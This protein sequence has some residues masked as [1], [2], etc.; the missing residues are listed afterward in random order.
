M[1]SLNIMII[2]K[3]KLNKDLVR[4]FQYLFFCFIFSST[5][6]FG[7]EIKFNGLNRL[8]VND[9]QTI[10]SIPL[11][12]PFDKLSINKL[13]KELYMSDFIYD[14]K[15]NEFSDFFEI[16][17]TES[18]LVKNIYFNGNIQI[19]DN[20]LLS[21]IS[22]KIDDFLKLDNVNQD[23]KNIKN[24]Y[25]SLGYTNLS[26]KVNIE[27]FSG[28]N[29]NL[30]FSI[31]ENDPFKISSI[32]FFGNS[33]FSNRYLRGRIQTKPIKSFNIFSS[34]SNFN[35]SNIDYDLYLIE[36]LYQD[37]GYYDVKVSYQLKKFF[38]KY[39]LDFYINEGRRYKINKFLINSDID[40][41]NIIKK[42][43][44]I[45]TNLEKKI[46]DNFFY[47]TENVD[48][49]LNQLNDTLL[50]NNY[51]DIIFEDEISIDRELKNISLNITTKIN[52][53]IFIKKILINGNNITKDK[54]I[55]SRLNFEPGDTIY[56]ITALEKNENYLKDEAF[57]LDSS[58]KLSEI[59]NNSADIVVD[60]VENEKSGNLFIAGGYDADTGAGLSLG[61]SDNN[62]L[63]TGNKI[64]TNLSL[65]Q[66][67]IFFDIG[68]VQKSIK[69]PN[70]VTRYSIFNK[71][72]DYTSAYGFKNEEV[73]LS[74]GFDTKLNNN[75][76]N[77]I[78]IK[79]SATENSSPKNNAQ[80]ITD[81]IGNSSE[82][83]I[84]YKIKKSTLDNNI[85]PTNGSYNDLGLTISTEPFLSEA[86]FLRVSSKN[87]YYYKIKNTDSNFFVLSDLNFIE[88]LNNKKLKTI[89]TLSLGGRNFKGFD[90][91]GIGPKDTSGNYLG[92]KKK[93]TLSIGHSSTFLFDKN[94]NILLSNYLSL[95]SLW[96]NDYINSSHEVRSSFTTSLDI[97][98]PIGPLSFS[99]SLPLLK[100]D[101]DI[102]NNFAFSI[103]TTF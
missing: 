92:G 15:V 7:K 30:I 98:T 43:D 97:L 39:N 88:S 48:K 25:Q 82:L 55:R 81:N 59:K 54:A 28:S 58:I 42:I 5:I 4:I 63:G 17:I 66:E 56:D 91:R 83:S 68:V 61:I 34:G 32:N 31:N 53:N 2:Q 78:S 18:P 102:T 22:S 64:D 14:L 93:Y 47:E 89:N 60:I 74:L 103:G 13:T 44:F 65:N 96:D 45:K 70:L 1:I 11:D 57:I 26:V 67:N 94:D 21:I 29:A 87:T 16:N 76:D 99:Y 35:Q 73:G 8:T 10:S 69:N 20:E 50:D 51:N 9:L 84:S 85:Y 38:Y 72:N 46:N 49:I 36:K 100:E 79:I 101:N 62:I 23:T 6:F 75:L 52:E 3:I 90:F 80:A 27:K 12:N 77:S 41:Q 19:K 24:L 40:N 86:S 95:G 37:Y 71:Q 33:Q